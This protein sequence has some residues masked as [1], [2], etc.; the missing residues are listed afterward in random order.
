[1]TDNTGIYPCQCALRYIAIVIPNDPLLHT[2]ISECVAKLSQ[3]SYYECQCTNLCT[4][5]SLHNTQRLIKEI[6]IASYVVYTLLSVDEFT[7]LL[8]VLTSLL[9]LNLLVAFFLK[10]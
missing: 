4:N 8:S 6:D 2:K 5:L 9:L 3:R 7:A 1:M 10:H